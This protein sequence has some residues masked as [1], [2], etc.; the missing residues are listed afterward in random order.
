MKAFNVVRFRVKP[1]Q[2]K[3]FLDV[4]RKAKVDF[5]GFKKGYLV[6]TGDYSYCF[7]GQWKDIDSLAG[8]EAD[9]IKILDKFR[10]TLE[11]LGGGLGVTD[12]VGGEAIMELKP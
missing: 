2:E 4:H 11:D 9:M 10:D 5:P 6:K 1:G 7:I 8:A 3:K 12:P